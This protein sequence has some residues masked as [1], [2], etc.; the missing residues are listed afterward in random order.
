[1]FTPGIAY[2]FQKIDGIKSKDSFSNG[3]NPSYGISINYYLKSADSV[4]ILILN[5]KG[6]TIQTIKDKGKIGINRTWWNLRHDNY[7][8]PKLRTKPRGKEWVTLDKDGAREMFIYDLDIGPG[9]TPTLVPP[10]QYTIVLKVGEKEARQTMLINKDPNTKGSLNDIQRQYEFGMKIYSEVN[11]CLE[12]IDEMERMRAELLAKSKDAKAARA[13]LLLEEKIYNMEAKIFD[14]N[15]TG[16]RQDIFRNPARILERL[17]AIAKEGQTASADYP[18][19]DQQQEVFALLKT[20]LDEV[21][22]SFDQ[23]KNSLDFK[24]A[25]LK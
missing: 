15:L 9:M 19:T 20:R 8:F 1:M 4:R 5:Q 21:K 25:G 16:A 17:L 12:L 14:I 13:A 23:L 6:N 18:P 7:E 10:G 2:R 22:Q 3:K 11:T 24:R